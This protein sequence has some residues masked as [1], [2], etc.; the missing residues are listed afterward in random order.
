MKK[1]VIIIGAGEA[2]KMVSN[3]I[4]RNKKISDKYEII[5]FLDDDKTKDVIN[6]IPVLGGLDAV[7]R[8]SEQYNVDEIIISIPSADKELISSIIRKVSDLSIN[9]KIVPGI[10]DIIQGDVNWKQIRD[11]KPEDL[12]GR[13]EVG[14]EIDKIEN[15][16]IDKTV[17]ITGAGGSIGSEIVRHLFKLPIKKLIAF[18]RGENSIHNLIEEFHYEKRFNYVIGDIRDVS[19]LNHEI[20][21]YEPDIIFHAAAHKHLP[22]ME[23]YPDESVKN[24]IFGTHNLV[25]SAINNKIPKVLIISTDKAV[26]PSSVMGATKRVAEIIALSYNKFQSTTK[27]S[28]VRFGNVLGSRGSVIPTFK[29]RI[30][31][32]GP[33]NLTDPNIERFFMSIPEAARLVLKSI[34]IKEGAIFIL[35]MGRSIKI[36]DLAKNLIKLSGR[37]EEEIAIRITGLR[38]GEKLYEELSYK[39][40]NLTVSKFNKILIANES[41]N[42]EIN[43]KYIDK[44]LEEFL[45]AAN[46][47]DNFKIKSLLKKYIPEYLYNEDII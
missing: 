35:D 7:G 47:Y 26:N 3:D 24:N 2:G 27:F 17:F 37:K 14:I 15:E 42:P 36:V 5:G 41:E 12:L 28:I 43:K 19:K 40:E 45:F 44:M 11:V 18:G 39:K 20:K 16:Y 4:L 23:E 10:Y 31:S 21:K 34:S 29:K 1:R 38:K 8:I 32:G 9:I 13:E 30:E 22:L 6:H 25:T 46:D 33:I